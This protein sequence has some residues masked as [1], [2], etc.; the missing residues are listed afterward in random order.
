M[1]DIVTLV[2]ND[3]S[4]DDSECHDPEDPG[5]PCN[6]ELIDLNAMYKEVGTGVRRR[7]TQTDSCSNENRLLNLQA[8]VSL[9]ENKSGREK[10]LKEKNLPIKSCKGKTSR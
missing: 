10:L 8:K 1:C 7:R 6:R 3:F 4:R 2:E 5:D 9:V